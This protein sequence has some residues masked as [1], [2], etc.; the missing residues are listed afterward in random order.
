MIAAFSIVPFYQYFLLY[1]FLKVGNVRSI[2][3]GKKY[4]HLKIL[5]YFDGQQLRGK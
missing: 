3:I 4:I 5:K 1:S 2:Y